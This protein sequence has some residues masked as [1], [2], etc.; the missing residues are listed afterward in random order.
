MIRTLVLNADYQP[1][2]IYG[3]KKAILKS[4]E[5]ST[6][7]VEFH[8]KSVQ[9][10]HGREYTIPAVMVLTEHQSFTNRPAPYSKLNIYARDGLRCQYCS[11]QL[12]KREATLDHVC[13]RSAWRKKGIK[14]SPSIFTNV[15][16]CCIRCNVQKGDKMPSDAGM[17]LL[18]KP[19]HP[20]RGQVF[21]AKLQMGHIYDVWKPYITN[22]G[23]VNEQN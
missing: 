5:H 14:G 1:H 6:Y 7:T 11:E 21:A 4:F 2:D 23:L 17:K 16:T 8:N 13:P 15:V 10:S 3:W 22:Q 18:K 12:S 19:L 20:T 9:D